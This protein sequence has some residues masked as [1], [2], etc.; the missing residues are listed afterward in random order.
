MSAYFDALCAAM[1]V[2]AEH[3]K[4]LF[5]GQA[6]AFDGTAMS[7]T[8]R[9]LPP[10]KL[11]EFPVAED[12]QLGFCTGVA[13]NDFLPVSIFPRWNFLLLA[14]SQLVLHLDKLP[15]YSRYRPKVIIR[16]AVATEKPLYPG[17]QH[18]GDFTSAFRKMLRTVTC[19]ELRRAEDIVPQ[20][21]Q[22]LTREGSTLLVEY[23]ELYA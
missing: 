19:V 5:V 18:L 15:L 11:I 4:S 14:A 10:E 23:T 9:H 20:Y 21:R 17:P 8:L 16:T 13:L 2:I 1:S 7:K 3:P 22:A 12:C 6:V